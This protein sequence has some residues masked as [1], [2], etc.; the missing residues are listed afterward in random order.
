MPT[1]IFDNIRPFRRD[2]RRLELA[3]LELA[4]RN[5]NGTLFGP[6][7]KAAAQGPGDG[8]EVPKKGEPS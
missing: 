1:I 5:A 3:L 6:E 2:A 8:S 4:D 7:P